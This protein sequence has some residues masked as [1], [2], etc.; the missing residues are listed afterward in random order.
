MDADRASFPFL[1]K[2]MKPDFLFASYFFF[3]LFPSK[4]YCR[5]GRAFLFLA[6]GRDN[7]Q[8]VIPLRDLFSPFRLRMIEEFLVPPR[9]WWGGFSSLLFPSFLL[10]ILLIISFVF[11]VSSLFSV[12]KETSRRFL[13]LWH[14]F[15][16]SLSPSLGEK[17]AGIFPL[18][19]LFLRKG[20]KVPRHHSF[21][22]FPFPSRKDERANSFSLVQVE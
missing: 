5:Y 15:S 18:P 22:P 21:F 14:S 10:S 20:E 7:K 2:R 8:R 16:P 19:L 4:W 17:Y 6:K 13:F 12:T 3:F 1:W 11:R 9:K